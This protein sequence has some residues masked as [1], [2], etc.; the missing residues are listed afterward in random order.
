MPGSSL[1]QL[2]ARVDQIAG[3]M[4]AWLLVVVIGLGILNL[5]VL[6]GL[7]VLAMATLTADASPGAEYG[8][9]DNW[10]RPRA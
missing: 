6:V 1:R 8:V 9:S 3:E 10:V 5:S 4:N 7:D 2:L